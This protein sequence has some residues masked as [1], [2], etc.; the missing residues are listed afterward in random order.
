MSANIRKMEF[1]SNVF[2]DANKAFVFFCSLPLKY[3]HK[4]KKLLTKINKIFK[5]IL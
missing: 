2:G 1:S 4:N 3:F 5:Y